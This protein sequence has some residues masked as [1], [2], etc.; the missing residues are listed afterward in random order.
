VLQ[1]RNAL[2]HDPTAAVAWLK[3]LAP[4]A[5]NWRDGIA[6]ARDAEA[7]GVAESVRRAHEGA[8]SMVAVAPDGKHVATSSHDGTMRL[9]DEAGRDVVLPAGDGGG[10]PGDLAFGGSWLATSRGREL[11]LWDLSGSPRV[12][13]RRPVADQ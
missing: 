8:I 2:E 13:A 11:E 12:V 4:D 7:R 6:I 1:A 9:W 5:K 10:E 3:Q